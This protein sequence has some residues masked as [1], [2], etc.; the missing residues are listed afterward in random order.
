[1][2][3]RDQEIRLIKGR[4]VR[5]TRKVTMR[6]GGIDDGF[7]SKGGTVLWSVHVLGFVDWIT[8]FFEWPPTPTESFETGEAQDRFDELFEKAEKLLCEPPKEEKLS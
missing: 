8:F 1:M 6:V 2:K 4:T 7:A 5:V 3:F